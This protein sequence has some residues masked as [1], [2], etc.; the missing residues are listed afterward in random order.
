[1]SARGQ[2]LSLLVDVAATW[3]LTRLVA[4]DEITRPLREAATPG[5]RV[6]YLLGCP[7]CV[8]V[9]A[10]M[11]VTSGVIPT[12]VRMALALSAGAIVVHEVLSRERG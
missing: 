9:W 4:E 6:E 2:A 8:S 11:A 5:S 3:R 7:Y 10:G 12:R 1:M